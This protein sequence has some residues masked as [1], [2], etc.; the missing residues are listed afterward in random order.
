MPVG[1]VMADT[2]TGGR[3]A[4]PAG[5]DAVDRSLQ[6]GILRFPGLGR[7]VAPL[8]REITGVGLRDAVCEP[9]IPVV[10]RPLAFVG[11]PVAL[12][13]LAV[14]LVGHPVAVVGDAVAVVGHALPF[15]HRQSLPP[16]FP[17]KR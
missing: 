5:M 9:G 16:R 17:Q 15:K 12:V 13:G 14:A 1:L 2:V 3:I 7:P 4:V 11:K 8:G 10:R 6:V